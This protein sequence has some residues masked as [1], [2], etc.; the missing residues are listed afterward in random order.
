[1]G[2]SVPASKHDTNEQNKS[3]TVDSSES[4]VQQKD[5]T[6]EELRQHSR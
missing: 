6:E 2:M 1:M 4:A 3:S 5:Q